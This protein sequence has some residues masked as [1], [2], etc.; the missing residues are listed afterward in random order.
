[1]LLDTGPMLGS[2]EASVLAQEADGAVMVICRG[3]HRGLVQKAMRRLRSLGTPVLGFV[4][5]RAKPQDFQRSVCAS[6][7]QPGDGVVAAGR[8]PLSE[9][10]SLMRFGPVVRAVAST[11]PAP[12][13]STDVAPESEDAEEASPAGVH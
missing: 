2:I 5:N 3:Q 4:F 11:L 6:A 7:S 1:V 12:Q 13:D 10:E 8:S 9:A